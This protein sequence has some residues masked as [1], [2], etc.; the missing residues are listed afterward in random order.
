MLL[1]EHDMQERQSAE[2]KHAKHKV[3]SYISNTLNKLVS[4]IYDVSTPSYEER[5]IKEVKTEWR[6]KLD[7]RRRKYDIAKRSNDRII[8]SDMVQLNNAEGKLFTYSNKFYVERNDYISKLND[9][10]KKS[11]AFIKS[12]N[13]YNADDYG[14][15]SKT[16]EILSDIKRSHEENIAKLDA[17][18]DNLIKTKE[19][20][21]KTIEDLSNENDKLN[22]IY[23]DDV[24]KINV[25]YDNKLRHVK[26]ALYGNATSLWKYMDNR[27]ED[28]ADRMMFTD[29][30]NSPQ[31]YSD[32]PA[33]QEATI[34]NTQT[35]ITSGSQVMQTVTKSIMPSR[36]PSLAIQFLDKKGYTSGQI[37]YIL[38]EESTIYNADWTA[39]KSALRKQIGDKEYFDFR[40]LFLGE[41][42]IRD[43]KGRKWWNWVG[44]LY[45]YRFVDNEDRRDIKNIINEYGL[46]SDLN[47]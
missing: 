24:R 1:E 44:P 4:L 3:R 19:R 37:N 2:S 34:E 42:R 38:S 27:E 12:V 20:M 6:M 8:N 39:R 23:R 10:K 21:S 15:E 17:E 41:S 25:N 14:L 45:V 31:I 28:L 32:V 16:L 26:E 35:N 22:K 40:L 33:I 7:E 29:E 5:R 18:H 47:L 11:R 46:E 9:V 13:G 36:G 30:V 43:G